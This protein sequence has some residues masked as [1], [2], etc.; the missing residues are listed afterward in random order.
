MWQVNLWGP[1][2]HCVRYVVPGPWHPGEREIWGRKPR[3]KHTIANCSQTVNPVL[4]PDKYKWGEWFRLLPN[5]FVPCYYAVIIGDV[6]W[7]HVGQMSQ[8]CQNV[9]DKFV[10]NVS[11][12][13][14][15]QYF[16]NFWTSWWWQMEIRTREFLN[17]S[18]R[19]SRPHR[20]FVLYFSN[21]TFVPLT[22]FFQVFIFATVD[23]YLFLILL[24]CGILL[25]LVS[26]LLSVW[27]FF[28]VTCHAV[29]AW[30]STYTKKWGG[31]KIGKL[32]VRKT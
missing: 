1:M 10:W 23:F 9:T 24:I 7:Q 6:W 22:I 13:G 5:Y 17:V 30:A 31:D 15:P 28:E 25:K 2:T 21:Y 32:L 8:H 29:C 16:W 11:G 3:P 27:C 19:N 14:W 4:P 18:R 12:E 26:R 20:N